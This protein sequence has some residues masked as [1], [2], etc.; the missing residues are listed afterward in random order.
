MVVELTCQGFSVDDSNE[1]EMSQSSAPSQHFIA[2]TF[3]TYSRQ[4][5][6]LAINVYCIKVCT[7]RLY[8]YTDIIY[9]LRLRYD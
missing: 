5:A 2:A 1:S 8:S 3:Q 4:T 7:Y 6:K 9:V